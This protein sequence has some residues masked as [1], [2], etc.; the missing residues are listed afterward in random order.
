MEPSSLPAR[1]EAV[2]ERIEQA[3]LRAGR[4]DPVTLVAV[5][6]THP[7]DAVRAVREAGVADVGENRVA[8]LEEKVGEVG[9]SAVRWHLIGHLQRNKVRRALPLFDLLHSLDSLPLAEVLSAEAERAGTEVRALV[10]VNVSGEETKG[11]FESDEAIDALGRI[12]DMPGIRAEG[13]MTMAPFTDDAATLRRTFRAARRLW[14]EAGLQ[15]AGFRPLYLSM[16]MSNDFEIAVEEGA[17]LVRVGSS[18][19]GERG[20]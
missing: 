8:E 19:F 5:T 15:V 16:G 20:A 3:R 12:Y 14:E 6:K 9:R 17:T 4:T 11:G 10:Q 1:V 18:I 7:A 2:R 13:L